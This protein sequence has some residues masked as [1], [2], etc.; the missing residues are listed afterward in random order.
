MV[1]PELFVLLV[2]LWRTR[3]S[4]FKQQRLT[5]FVTTAVT[6]SWD[7]SARMELR[8]GPKRNELFTESLNRVALPE[9]SACTM[10]KTIVLFFM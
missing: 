6:H 7:Y 10:Q 8:L 4:T 5:V 1:L 3:D 9:Q 2:Q